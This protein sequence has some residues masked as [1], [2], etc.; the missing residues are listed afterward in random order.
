MKWQEAQSIADKYVELLKPYCNR[1]AI[2][3]SIRRERLV[4]HDIEI[5]CI[6][7][8]S[9]LFGFANEVDRLLRIKGRAFG[10]YTQRALPEGINL[11]LFMCTKE[12][13][14]LIY[15]IRTGSARYSH[16]VL[17]NGWVKCGFKSVDGMLRKEGNAVPVYEEEDLFKLIGIDYIEPTKR[18]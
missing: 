14:G 17:A 2:A 8:I 5:V 15:A 7:N 16:K 11:D 18:F 12:N 3:G 9:K 4:V 10:K 1:I 6:R 13:W